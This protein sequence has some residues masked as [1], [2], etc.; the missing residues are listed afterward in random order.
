MKSITPGDAFNPNGV[1]LQ[2]GEVRVC[3]TF[4]AAGGG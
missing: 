2:E 1:L 3:G 4:T